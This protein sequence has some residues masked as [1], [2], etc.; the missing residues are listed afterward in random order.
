MDQAQLMQVEKLCQALYTGTSPEMRAEAQQQLLTLQSTA[1]FI[2]QCQFILDNSSHV[3]AQVVATTSLDALVTQ[4]WNNFTNQQ[5]LD[6]RN[7]FI[8]FLA[9]HAH[10]LDEFVATQ[11]TRLCGKISKFGWFDSPEFRD[12]V[13]ESKKFLDAT[14]DHNI[15]GMR[16]LVSLVDE[17]NTQTPG[18]TLTVHRKT[19]MSFRDQLLLAIFQITITSLRSLQLNIQGRRPQDKELK[20]MQFAL[21]LACNTLSF[22]FIGT[23]PEE[24]TEDVGTVQVPSSW[25]TIIQESSTMQLFFDYY[26]FCE[27]PRSNLALEVLVQLSSVRRSLFTSEKERSLFLEVLMAGIRSIM[28]SKKGLDR[29]ENYHE[30]CR[31]VGR[32]KASYQLSELV[33]TASFTEWLELAGDFTIKSL[34]NWQYSMNSIHY[35]LSLWGRLVAALPYLRTDVPDSQRQAQALRTCV[36]QVVESY[37]KTMLDSVEVVV[38]SDGVIEDPLDDEGSLR[39]QMERLPVIAR[40][41]YDTVA[42]YLLTM[43]EQALGIYEQCLNVAVNPQIAVIEGKMTWLTYIVAA[44]I[45]AQ[46]V[47]ESRKAQVDLVWDGRLSRCVF[48]LIQM[49]NFRLTNSNGQLKVDEK[50]E[51]ALLYYFKAFK[52]VY[53]LESPISTITP[54]ISNVIVPGGVPAH[55]MLSLALSSFQSAE[56]KVNADIVT[57]SFASFVSLGFVFY[58]LYTLKKKIDL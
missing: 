2:P 15:I 58:L 14:I 37:I 25:R 38:R 47:T 36:L 41:Q 13:E 43:F 29:E 55:P 5:K 34:Q 32:L 16:I 53:L 57:V 20:L 42:Q 18:K 44:V 23:N 50:L 22:D 28:Q 40:L 35:L 6:L 45:D 17:M 1:D 52:K 46:A 4:F 27:P 3:Y 8:M 30:F 26:H 33:K 39:E 7:Y 19:A 56:E 51:I 11:L 31:L 54:S 21:S 10:N 49:I 12:I 48:Q 24:S 9:S